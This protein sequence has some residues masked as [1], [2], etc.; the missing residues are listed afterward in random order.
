MGAYPPVVLSVIKITFILSVS[1]NHNSY[2]S[3][4]NVWIYVYDIHVSVFITDV[5]SVQNNV[6]NFLNNIVFSL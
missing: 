4:K 5:L 2:F 3:C 1:E 6:Q